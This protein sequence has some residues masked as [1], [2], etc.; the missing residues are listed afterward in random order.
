MSNV[1]KEIIEKNEI[2][3]SIKFMENSDVIYAG[4][5][6]EKYFTK[7]DQNK[8]IEIS[9]GNGMTIFKTIKFELKEN[10][11]VFCHTLFIDCLF[12]HLK[13]ITDLK[14]IKLITSQTDMQIT[15]KIFDQKPKCISQWFSI[16]VSYENKNLIP[17]PLGIVG[18]ANSKNLS[19][20]NLENENFIYDRQNK[21]YTNFNLNTNYFHRYSVIK[22][23][24]KQKEFVIE[25]PNMQLGDYIKR[26]FDYK[27]NITPW[28]NG[29]DTH[30]LWESVYAGCI[31][32]TK[33][34]IT[35]GNMQD[36]PIIFLESYKNLSFK[37]ISNY[38]FENLN[39]NKLKFSW[40]LN[41]IKE[42][43]LPDS[44][45]VHSFIEDE[46]KHKLNL[47]IFYQK[48]H[49]LDRRKKYITIFRKA[50]KKLFGSKVNNFIGI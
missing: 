45:I 6:H 4:A 13:N 10:D 9:N 7:L 2:I 30:R 11:I 24:F 48:Y 14:N 41:V 12:N 23:I 50:H 49:A 5:V 31:P 22:K 25:K 29:I 3:T 42:K 40:W 8:F 17:I 33:K 16:N 19:K 46:N 20:D 39:L 27:Y 32:I 15:K 18:G 35:F 47:G 44:G 34:H 21:V 43:T 1:I 38:H 28:G 37:N 26:L 36:L